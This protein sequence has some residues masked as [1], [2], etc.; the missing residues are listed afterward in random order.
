MTKPKNNIGKAQAISA[1][2][3][4]GAPKKQQVYGISHANLEQFYNQLFSKKDGT[5]HSNH[6]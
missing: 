6:S 1:T 5:K 2:G 4:D 3:N